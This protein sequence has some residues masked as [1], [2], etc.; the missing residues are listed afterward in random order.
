MVLRSSNRVALHCRRLPRCTSD[1]RYFS[2]VP[3][4]RPEA[5]ISTQRIDLQVSAKIEGD[6]SQIVTIELRK[7]EKLRA[8]SGSMIYMTEGTNERGRLS[9]AKRKTHMTVN[10]THLFVTSYK[11]LKWIPILEKVAPLVDG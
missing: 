5:E 10:C 9:S 3:A 1:I 8:E 2:T 11:A 7:G 4:P 6:E